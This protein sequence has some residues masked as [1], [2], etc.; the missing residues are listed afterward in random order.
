MA[1]Q[2]ASS[3]MNGGGG[4]PWQQTMA[5]GVNSGQSLPNMDPGK[6]ANPYSAGGMGQRIAR[7]R[8]GAGASLASPTASL[9]NPT[10]TQ[11]P[12]P[13]PA[14]AQ[15]TQPA[16]PVPPATG[17]GQNPPNP[18]MA[19]AISTSAP[20]SSNPGG[21]PVTQQPTAGGSSYPT[22]SYSPVA[23]TIQPSSPTT[24]VFNP[25]QYQDLGG[26]LASE[27]AGN[28]TPAQQTANKQNFFDQYYQGGMADANQSAGQ[29]LGGVSGNSTAMQQQLAGSIASAQT[30]ANAQQA[31]QAQQA[32]Q[33]LLGQGM[34]QGEFEQ[35]LGLQ[36]QDL[37]QQATQAFNSLQGQL[38]GQQNQYNIAQLNNQG[39]IVQSI[40]KAISPNISSGVTQATAALGM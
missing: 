30:T 19:R 25:Q 34:Q 15:P 38:A 26:L 18:Y 17:S 7:A 10:G 20:S 11:V 1:N 21:I 3:A 29:G 35:N 5:S 31:Q 36:N 14:A 39:G 33:S 32:L 16:A 27:A 28:L 2:Y 4:N 13:A 8:S 40:L 9:A 12:A 6:A 24:S 22:Q 37:Q 23:Q